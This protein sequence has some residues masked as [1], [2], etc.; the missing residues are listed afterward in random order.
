MIQMQTLLN[1]LITYKYDLS[2]CLANCSNKGQCLLNQ[3][4][5][6]YFCLCDM[7]YIGKACQTD[8][9]PCSRSLYCLNNGTCVNV[10]S[11]SFRCEC[12]EN[13]YGI[14]CENRVNICEN[15]TC[16]KN[17]YCYIN[18][19]GAQCKCFINYYGDSCET[20][21]EFVRI[22]QAVTSTSLIIFLVC[23]SLFVFCIVSNDLCNLMIKRTRVTKKLIKTNPKSNMPPISSKPIRFKY[24]A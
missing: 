8:S 13:F 5:S 15:V 14:Y 19:S 20:Q 6:E 3:T 23:L 2:A 11:T 16:S 1:I 24:H 21:G 7:N 10:N 18:E 22:I 12:T 4:M 17:G 9:M